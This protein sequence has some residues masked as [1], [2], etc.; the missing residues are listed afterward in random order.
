[1]SY[2]AR[3]QDGII[4]LGIG[5]SSISMNPA[6]IPYAKKIIRSLE[7][8]KMKKL[9][10]NVLQFSTASEIEA[11][12]HKELATIIPDNLQSYKPL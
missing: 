6:S 8:T 10:D 4:L 11:C 1:M 5:F 9:V 2:S 12:L 7:I 3:F